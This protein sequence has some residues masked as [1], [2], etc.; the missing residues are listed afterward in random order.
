MIKVGTIINTHG[1]KGECKIMLVTDE[2]ND[3]FSKGKILQ[4]ANG[5][6]L[7]VQSFRVQ[8]GF[9]YC[10]FE[11]IQSIEEAEKYKPMDLFIDEKE[12]PALNDGHFYYFELMNC[13]VINEKDEVLGQV[14]D[15][16]ETGANIVLRVQDGKKQFLCP[17]VPAFIDSVDVD[18]KKIYIKEMEGLR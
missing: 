12:L 13:Q 11:E 17:F 8:K 6:T 2:A 9:G 16:L 18:E 7:T 10:R 14:I 1:L 15:I 4:A 5:N 3:R